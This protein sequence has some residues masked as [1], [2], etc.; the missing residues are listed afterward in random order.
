MKCGI[1]VW[2]YFVLSALCVGNVK[3]MAV[4]RIGRVVR[5]DKKVIRFS[6]DKIDVPDGVMFKKAEIVNK[7]RESNSNSDRSYSFKEKKGDSGVKGGRMFWVD[8]DNDYK[9]YNDMND[10]NSWLR[11]EKAL[12]RKLSDTMVDLINDIINIT[13]TN[14]TYNNYTTLTIINNI[15]NEYFLQQ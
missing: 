7:S 3:G 14:N 15:F 8:N 1:M 4:K 12:Q 6:S 9:E 2:L 11:T 13:N 5:G 10:N